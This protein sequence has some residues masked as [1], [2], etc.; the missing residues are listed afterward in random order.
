MLNKKKFMEATV[1]TQI[2]SK[3]NAIPMVI[4]AGLFFILGFVTWMNGSLMPYLKQMFKL[5][6]EYFN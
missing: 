4:V 3:S 5:L 6:G 2:N 1:D